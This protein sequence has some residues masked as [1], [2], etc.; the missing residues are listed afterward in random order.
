MPDRPEYVDGELRLLV[1][2]AEEFSAAF[3]EA[4]DDDKDLPMDGRD[5][6]GTRVNFNPGCPNRVVKL[7]ESDAMDSSRW[8]TGAAL[9]GLITLLGRD[10]FWHQPVLA[11]HARLQ[12]PVRYM[13]GHLEQRVRP[14]FHVSQAADAIINK[15]RDMTQLNG[16]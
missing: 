2:D 13:P 3:V 16:A 6:R 1:L 15:K 14:A 9:L 12:H 4:R 7:Q 11:R 10:I 5:G 8:R